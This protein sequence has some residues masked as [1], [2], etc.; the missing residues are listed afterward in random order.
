MIENKYLFCFVAVILLFVLYQNDCNGQQT[1]PNASSSSSPINFIRTWVPLKPYTNE[2]DIIQTVRNPHEVQ[3]ATQYFDGLGRPMQMVNRQGSA[4]RKDLVQ[5]NFYDDIGREARKY[6][7]VVI[8]TTDGSYKQDLIDPATGNYSNQALNYYNNGTADKI[9]DDTRPFSEIIF[10]SSPLNRPS[11]EFGAGQNWKD[12]NKFIQHQYLINVHGT[13]AG[14][15]QIIAWKV[16][17]TG[18]PIRETAVNAAVSGG[19]Y[20]SA[21]LNIKSTKDEQGNEVREYVDK[22][23]QTILKKVQAVTTPVLNTP[24]HWT[25][26]YYIYDD[27]GN[28]RYVLQPELSKTLLGSATANPTQQQLN[29]LAFQYKYDGRRRMTEKKV[30]GAGWVYM[31]YDNRDRLVLTQEGNQRSGTPATIKYWNF[32]K[33][34]ELNRPIL[35][36]IKDTTIATAT[37]LMTQADMQ[38]VVNNYYLKAS[39][40]W[41]ET[42]VGNVAG[43]V[44][45]Y[46]NRAYP[47]R[48][49]ST[50]TEIDPNKYLSATYYDNYS[51]R[52]LWVGNYTY[53]DESLS[54]T[55]NGVLYSQPSVENLQVIGQVTGTKTKVLDGGVRGGF[56]WLKSV[57][58]YDDKYRAVQSIVDNYKG[59]TD[60]GTNVID[61]VGKVLKTR[62]THEEKDVTWKDLVGV[63]LVG[64]KLTR[65]T[66]TA[67]GAASTQV[68]GASQN[69]WIELVVSE[70][71]TSRYIGFNDTNSDVGFTNIDYAFH[72]NSNTLRIVEN[73]VVRLT[74]TGVL[75]PGDVLRIERV[76][77]LIRY[78]R[79]GSPLSY[80]NNGA[81]SAALM[82]DVSLQSNNATLTGVRTS[83]STTSKTIGRRLIY[84]HAGRLLKTFHSVDG[85]TEIIL[86]QNEYNEVG[87]LVDKKLHS[88]N[89]GTSFKQSVDY[90]YN[91]RGWLRSMNNSQLTVNSDNDEAGDFFGMELGYNTGIGSGNTS[92]FNGNISGI[93]W[94]KDQALGTVKDVAY[95][96]TYDPLNRILSASYLNNTAGTW[97]N[98]T[99][100]FSESGYSYD[101]NGNIN[102]LTRKGATGANMDL[103]A[104]NYGTVGNVAYGNQLLKVGDTGDKTTGFI[105]GANTTNDYTYD[106]N[107]NMITDQNKGITGVITYN[108]LNLPELITR[109]TSNTI[110]YIYDAGGRKLAQVASYN[111]AQKQTEYMGEFQYENDVLQHINH[112]EGRIVVSSTENQ[113]TNSGDNTTNITGTNATPALVTQNGTQTYIKATSNGTVARTGITLTTLN[114]TA[115]ERYIVRAKGYRDK[116]TST[117]SNPVYLSIKANGVDQGWPGAT[118]ASSVATEAWTEQIVTVPAGATTLLVGMGWNTTVTAGEV[119]FVNDVEI[120][121]I[122]TT[123]PE[124]QYHLKDHLGNVRLTFTTKQDTEINT[125]TMETAKATTEQGQFLNYSE[126]IKINATIFDRSHRTPDGLSNTTFYSTRLTGGTTNAVNGLAKSLS[127]MPGDKVDVEVFAKYL[128]PN[129]NNWSAALANFMASIAAGGGAPAGT[130]IDGN[131]P[132]SLGNSAFPFP[133]Q[134]VRD[135]DNGTGPKAYLNYLLFDRDYVY[136]T[137]GFKR[138][139]TA[140]IERGT[141]VT[142]ERLF[143]DNNEINITEAGFLYIWLSNENETPIEV[144]FDDFKVTHTKSPVIQSEDYYPFGLTFNSYSRENSVANQYKFNGKEE[145]DELGLGW[146]DYGARMYMPD[147][148][149]WGVV[150]PMAEKG[151]RHS[152]Y[153]YAFNNPVRFI[154]PD[155]MWPEWSLSDVVHTGLDVVGMIPGVG[156]VADGLNAVIYLAEGDYGNAAMS[157]AA[158]IPGAGNAVTVAKFA[159][160][161]DLAVTALKASDE[162]A[163]GAKLAD[164]GSDAK[165]TYQT[166]TKEA[167]DP[168][169]H[170]D[171]SGKTSGTKTPEENIA[172]RDQGHHMNKTHGP[173]K[174]DKSSSNPDA[175]R[176]REQQNIKSK[177]GAIS[178]GGTSGN[179]INGVSPKNP[180]KQRYQDAANKEFGT[181]N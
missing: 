20:L 53:L 123:A 119:F 85:A 64:N 138:L 38:A 22:E 131:F 153:N 106:A 172:K 77:A 79:N 179:A 55:V 31:V 93:K 99:G 150:D 24:A 176:G 69:G 166:Y 56:T 2:L 101:Q 67:A 57:N 62:T 156:E 170:G 15:E 105:D 135:G 139:T 114:V 134:L 72:L 91:I 75:Q 65:T 34:D 154:D 168:T 158:M 74:Q 132:G 54:E 181:G 3:Q 32:T 90:R 117:T 33:Y 142:H 45:G 21:Q 61:F 84:D 152:P 110:R 160:K 144:Y 146:L 29:N 30:P 169:K 102:A 36:G 96:Y 171:Y 70:I 48:T 60:R 17:A 26:T 71:N 127:V 147:I 13:L 141:D 37:V 35:T 87:Q 145:Q 19:Y 5:T 180:N 107:G 47:V 177:G 120:N 39:A 164:K 113:Y 111:S 151:R 136:K 143:F 167:K 125:A 121:K 7:P 82:V 86:T 155:G 175:I 49:G 63:S 16:D 157:A 81:I 43:N 66:T 10:E 88:T 89:S 27:L 97:A 40:R 163:A 92:L 14:Q 118:L 58:Y 94:S 148:G 11:Q 42:Y 52:S 173:A 83:F 12:N 76:G 18:L 23:G 126:A 100:A 98:S 178:E 28:L 78:F 4:A 41:S 133:G 109:G 128:D 122:A 108:Y 159:K 103:L 46:T 6:L 68:L 161:A 80:Q 162:V 51:F 73:N 95:N 112:E 25:S 104:Y 116:G 59:G 115:G 174:L 124:Y 1:L 130:I 44:H 165:K 137:G 140:A 149:R 9:A 8:N 129:S 50:T